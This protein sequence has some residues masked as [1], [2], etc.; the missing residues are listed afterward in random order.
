[1]DCHAVLRETLLNSWWM[2]M[3]RI[4]GTLVLQLWGKNIA[5]G[6]FQQLSEHPFAY[7]FGLTLYCLLLG[8]KEERRLV[9]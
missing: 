7:P 9:L 8:T 5:V 4:F 6:F 2:C 3:S 1:M